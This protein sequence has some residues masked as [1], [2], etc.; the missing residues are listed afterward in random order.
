MH[1]RAGAWKRAV[2][3]M[4]ALRARI[5]GEW[6]LI[7]RPGFSAFLFFRYVNFLIIL[8]KALQCSRCHASAD[9][10]RMEAQAYS[11]GCGGAKAR[12]MV[13]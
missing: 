9:H 12:R 2:E 8:S 6:A 7:S 1:S 10:T 4:L 13:E 5:E 11:T 3:N